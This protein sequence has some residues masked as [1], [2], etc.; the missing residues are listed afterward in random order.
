[1]KF[2][3]ITYLKSILTLGLIFFLSKGNAQL[4]PTDKNALDN[5]LTTLSL[6]WDPTSVHESNMI[7]AKPQYN[8]SNLTGYFNDYFSRNKYTNDLANYLGYPTFFWLGND[9]NLKLQTALEN[10]FS[11]HLDSFY[12][13]MD[14]FPSAVKN[15]TSFLHDV[16]NKISML[17]NLASTTYSKLGAAKLDSMNVFFEKLITN[18]P[19]LKRNRVYP[20]NQE[21]YIARLAIGIHA[22]WIN[23]KLQDEARIEKIISVIQLPSSHAR[24]LRRHKLFI[25]DNN[26]MTERDLNFLDTLLTKVPKQI[27][28][29]RFMSN[30]GYLLS[31]NNIQLNTSILIEAVNVFST[32]GGFTE[33]GFA[34]EVSPH[35]VDGFCLVAAHELSHRFD[36]DYIDKDPFLLARK[37]QLI[38]Q[39]GKNKMNYL[40]SMFPDGFFETNPQEFIASISN[41]YMANTDLTLQMALKKFDN[42]FKE[43]LNQFLF[44]TDIISAKTNNTVFYLNNI[45]AELSSWNAPIKRNGSNQII[46]LIRDS[47]RYKFSLDANGNAITYKKLA[48]A[49]DGPNEICSQE[50]KSYTTKTGTGIW[51]ISDNSKATIDTKGLLQAV[52]QGNIVLSFIDTTRA[53]LD[54]INLSIQIKEK[55]QKPTIVK[56]NDNYLLSPSSF[57]NN[58]FND[59]KQLVD[60]TPKY[61]PSR[62]GYYYLNIYAEGCV[63]P[64]SENFYFITT[65]I[66]NFE[67]SNSE[68]T[69]TKN[70]SLLKITRNVQ[71][72]KWVNLVFY[73]LNGKIIYSS[74]NNKTENRIDL[75]GANKGVYVLSI[76][77]NT[78]SF[79]FNRKIV[80][81]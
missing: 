81:D 79:L 53:I 8:S 62:N 57:G 63:S 32:I 9:V 59:I 41:Q 51:K 54:T 23:M 26:G 75:S 6:G 34:Q 15:N 12:I 30:S 31:S 13:K 14:S 58:W 10:I 18:S 21:P 45:K 11:K 61:R 24:L 44:F 38:S 74:Y 19:Y 4:S 52:A 68:Y 17:A 35:T 69:I 66:S 49:I 1:M 64:N 29:L 76:Q 33:N 25:A 50:N 43:P 72:P 20:L 16:N 37:R 2:T 65:S 28:N 48:I 22:I 36:P 78:G 80:V 46:E 60:T 56:S 67:R 5:Y 39:A 70:G 7:F 55:P 47:I 71:T 3:K 27:H 42:G 73:D 40:R 77:E